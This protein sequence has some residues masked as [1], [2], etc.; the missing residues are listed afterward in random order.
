[1][2][3]VDAARRLKHLEWR[4]KPKGK[5]RF[6]FAWDECE[7]LDKAKAEMADLRALNHAIADELECEFW[8][9]CVST[10]FR[11]AS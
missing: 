1:M 5:P 3:T 7:N 8:F 6:Y 2:L 9:L 10:G 11:I 4:D